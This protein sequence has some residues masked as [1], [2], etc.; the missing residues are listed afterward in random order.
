MLP[1][2]QNVIAIDGPA[3]AG[4][5]TVAKK[6]AEKLGFVYVD[7][8]AMYRAVT[9]HAI[10]TGI[11][12]EDV[13]GIAGV[14]G[15]V[16]IR[17]TQEAG[18]LHVWA[19]GT[20]VTEKIRTP[21]VT[22]GV[23]KVSQVPEVRQAMVRLQREMAAQGSAV[24]D[25]RDIGTVVLP[26]ACCKVFLTAST[27][28]R[29]RRRWQEMRDKGYEQELTELQKEIEQRDQQDSG[30]ELAPLR[31]AADAALIDTTGVSIDEVVATIVELF[32][33][34]SRHV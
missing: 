15:T 5:S 1:M 10:D 24:L 26:D 23:A 32:R 34:R 31:Q 2:K 30:R 33:E 9:S 20:D 3:G 29:A 25:G 17:L 22:A 11:G 13:E 28:E 7:T 18:K 19:D 12:L 6:V 8:G 4:K 14:A 27:E 16:S 21:A